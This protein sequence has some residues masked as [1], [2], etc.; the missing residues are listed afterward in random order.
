MFIDKVDIL[1]QAGRGGNGVNSFYRDK[2]MR[3]KN[4]RK[5]K[6]DGGDGGDGGS[7]IIKVDT[8]VI[9]LLDFYYRKKFSAKRASNG[10][11]KDRRGQNGEDCYIH[12][13][14][15]TLVKDKKDNCILRDLQFEDSS[16]I[17]AK[18]GR[19]G[20]GNRRA[21]LASEGKDGEIKKITLELKLV[22]DVGLVG[23]PNAGKSTLL[24]K[25]SHAKPKIA[26]YPFT[27]KSPVLG[28]VKEED[29]SFVEIGR[30]SCRERV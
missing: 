22:A 2:F 29:S 6:P 11:G 12:V 14:P 9:S 28:I 16:L 3:S 18:G 1:V 26:P 20:R 17:V 21:S 7:V 27:T 19:G 13:P 25:I 23:M 5:G 24:S 30:A 8:N 15:G 10:K 4:N